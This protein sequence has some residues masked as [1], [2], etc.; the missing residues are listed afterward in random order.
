VVLKDGRRL[1]VP[2]ACFPRL[3]HASAEAREAAEISACG[4]H[5][6]ALGED[7]SVGGCS[8]DAAIYAQRIDTA[9]PI[10]LT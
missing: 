8:P 10:V 9:G 2:L 7:I 6:E 5:W 3:M 1:G 4:L